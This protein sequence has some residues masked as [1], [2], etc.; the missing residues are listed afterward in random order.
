[1]TSHLV[2][3][4]AFDDVELLDIAGP[5]EVFTAADRLLGEDATGYQTLIVGSARGPVRCA[6]GVSL[7]AEASWDD[8]DDNIDTLIVPGTLAINQ[9]RPGGRTDASLVGWLA[10]TGRRLPRIASVCTGAFTLAAAGL[11][12]HRRATTH[13]AFGRQLAAEYPATNVDSDAIFIR[14]ER[15]WTSAGVSAGIDLALAL[16]ADD[17]N[18]ELARRVA[19][20]LVLYL[21][22]QGGQSQFSEFLAHSTATD[23]EIARL[24]AWIPDHLTENLS[25][26]AL[27]HQVGISVRH[28]SRTFRTQ[29][30]VTP[31]RY[32]E[33]IRI[34][35]AARR[36]V[37]TDSGLHSIAKAVGFGSVET[38]YRVFNE[39]YGTTPSAYREHFATS[40][41]QNHDP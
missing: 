40:G 7:L 29:V 2:A 4:A 38:F 10:T 34:G 14:Q 17:H 36:L 31:G 21:R 11:L 33:S 15:I 24:Q 35:A 22:R 1:M 23:A 3:I 5:I 27:A 26:E 39:H 6:G 20:W 12:D 28:F 25:N 32:V 13:W 19:R 18:T 30:G 37:H 9:T 16:V 41:S 8:V